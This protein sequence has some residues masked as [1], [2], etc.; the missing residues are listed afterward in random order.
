MMLGPVDAAAVT[1][2]LEPPPRHGQPLEPTGADV[3]VDG[4]IDFPAEALPTR[5]GLVDEVVGLIKE[6]PLED[7]GAHSQV[8]E[9]D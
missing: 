1:P 9:L 4:F 5:D 7:D 2:E 6:L 3:A 8:V